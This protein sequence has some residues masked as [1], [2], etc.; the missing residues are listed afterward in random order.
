MF[1]YRHAFHAANHADVLKHAILVQILDYFNQKEAPYWVI[2][3][4]AGAGLYDLTSEWAQT[5]GEFENG[6][7][8]LLDDSAKPALI[9]RYLAAVQ[10]FNPDGYA[11]HY[12]G[13]PWLALQAMRPTDRLRL[14]EL[15]PTEVDVLSK[16][17]ARQSKTV[18]R[19]TQVFEKDGFEGLKALLPP[20]SR[21]A[22]VII[23][24][25]YENK[26]DYRHVLTALQDG[27]KRFPT[28]CYAVWYPKVQRREVEQL[29]RSL[30]KL[31]DVEWLHAQ[32]T[33]CKPAKDGHGLH[34]SGM[35][36]VNP[37]WTLKQELAQ[38]LPWLTQKLALDEHAGC[39]LK[40]SDGKHIL[41]AS[42]A[43][44][45]RPTRPAVAQKRS[46]SRK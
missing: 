30:E 7:D 24:P 20:P 27:L 44:A 9:E 32:L 36:V 8:R 28:G 45:A 5:N 35:F 38:A 19:Q 1:S 22:V 18:Q 26:N 34:G 12:P 29:L 14:F 4:H 25:S 40:T 41:P 10:A 6:L 16:N 43:K 3:T 13:S 11:D 31:P 39:I 23:D 21:R 37:P 15:H 42:P 33:V 17:L 2:D 46:P